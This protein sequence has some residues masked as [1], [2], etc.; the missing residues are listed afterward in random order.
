MSLPEL[1]NTCGK[2][3][4]FLN[5][6]L[7]LQIQVIKRMEKLGKE[8]FYGFTCRPKALLSVLNFQVAEKGLAPYFLFG[9]T[10]N[11]KKLDDDNPSF[12]DP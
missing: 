6:Y 10:F 8:G 5:G 3:G 7:C 11:R 9:L 12:F 4:E 1:A 2:L